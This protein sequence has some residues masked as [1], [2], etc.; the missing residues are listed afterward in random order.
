MTTEQVIEVIYQDA[1]KRT[2]DG[3][4]DVD[5]DDFFCEYTLEYRPKTDKGTPHVTP[6]ETVEIREIFIV[7]GINKPKT[8]DDSF[9]F[10]NYKEIELIQKEVNQ[11]LQ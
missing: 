10:W 4:Y 5:T 7:E 6:N 3:R 9:E 8:E 11:I 1:M 2:K